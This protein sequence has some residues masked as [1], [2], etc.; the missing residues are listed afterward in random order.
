[1]GADVAASPH[2]PGSGLAREGEDLVARMRDIIGKRGR[3]DQSQ[4]SAVRHHGAGQRA[5]CLH[6]PDPVHIRE[7]VTSLMHQCSGNMYAY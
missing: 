3:N 2:F 5:V 7:E 1:M 4:T 6:H